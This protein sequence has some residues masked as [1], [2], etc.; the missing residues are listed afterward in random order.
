MPK[1]K[2]ETN[3]AMADTLKAMGMVRP[4]VTPMDPAN[5]AQ[6]DGISVSQDPEQKLSLSAV[7]HKAFLEV[8]EKGTEAAAATAVMALGGAV[9]PVA[10][11]TPTFRADKP[12]VFVI[13]D[14]QTG[15]ILFLGRVTDPL[16]G[17]LSKG[18]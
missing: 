17:M 4:F 1:F 8:G 13:R 2:L 15:T 5:G 6:F 10:R 12:F 9:S 14:K 7:I 16:D 18:D 11:F 3:Y